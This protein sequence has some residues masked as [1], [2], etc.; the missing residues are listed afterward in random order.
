[1]DIACP[2]GKWN[3]GTYFNCLDCDTKNANTIGTGA[4]RWICRPLSNGRYVDM[5]GVEWS[6]GRA[7]RLV[8]SLSKRI[9]AANQVKQE[10][11]SRLCPHIGL[12]GVGR[13]IV[14]DVY[15]MSTDVRH[16]HGCLCWPCVGA[17]LETLAC[18]LV[19]ERV[20]TWTES[21]FQVNSVFPALHGFWYH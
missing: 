6:I 17:S 14:G 8:V 5:H 9:C 2:I 3:S 21:L 18:F 1:M 12:H 19:R 10:T 20:V 4:G 11:S 7:I 15:L 16:L 13:R